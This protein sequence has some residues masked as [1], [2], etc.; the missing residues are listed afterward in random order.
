[1]EAQEEKGSTSS[2]SEEE[3]SHFGPG[4]SKKKLTFDNHNHEFCGRQRPSE[5]E[6]IL[7][8]RPPKCV[9]PLVTLEEDVRVMCPRALG[10]ETRLVKAQSSL[11]FISYYMQLDGH[12]SFL[13]IT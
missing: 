10:I 5:L 8:A 4:S 3:L 13:C 2:W 9:M 6:L 1:M 7:Q 11:L 12:C